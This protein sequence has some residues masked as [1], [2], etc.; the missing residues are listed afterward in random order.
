MTKRLQVFLKDAEYREV[1]RAAR[2]RNMSVADWVRQ[3]LVTARRSEPSGTVAHKLEAIR[4]AARFEF[5]TAEIDAMRA[6]IESGYRA[7]TNL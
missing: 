6:E 5:P 2:S 1:Q 3:A 7:E 4:E